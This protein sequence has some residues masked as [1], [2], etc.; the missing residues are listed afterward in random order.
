MSFLLS[1]LLLIAPS[2][3]LPEGVT[4]PQATDFTAV[5]RSGQTFLTWTEEPGITGE[6]YRI[7]RSDLPID[8]VSLPTAD[9]LYEVSEGSAEFYAD[10]YDTGVGGV[11]TSRYLTHFVITDD[12]PE[13]NSS[14][15]LLVWTLDSTDFGGGTS[16]SGYYAIT[17][18]DQGVENTTDFTAA[19]TFGPV[20]ESIQD[21]TPVRTTVDIGPEGT[22]FIQYRDLRNWNPTFHAPNFTNLYYG[23][24]P[25]IPSVARSIQY[26]YVYALYGP[27]P[28]T[29]T[30][31]GPYP[32]MLRLHG[33]QGNA[34]SPLSADPFASY[35][36]YKL[37]P[38][39]VT[40]TW[41]FGFARDHDFRGGGVV[42][43][44]DTIV[45]YTEQRVLDMIV[46]LLAD[47]VFGPDLDPQ[48][49]YSF[50][51]SM[52]GS[53]SLALA[54]RYPDVFAGIY[55]CDPMTNY[56]T[57][58]QAGDTDWTGDA[59]LKWGTIAQNLPVEIDAP[60]GWADHLKVH[61]GTGVWDWQN[62]QSQLSLRV[63][64]EMVPLGTAHGTMDSVIG[65]SNQGQPLPGALDGSRRAWG[66][67]VEAGGHIWKDFQGLPPSMDKDA[68]SVPFDGFG[69][70]RDET[71]PGLSQA[72]SNPP[73][74]PAGAGDFNQIVEWSSS[75]DPF[76]GPPQDDP[77]CWC[78]TLRTVDGSTVT[79][80]V[81]PRRLQ[82]FLVTPGVDYTWENLSL[83]TGTVIESGT[84]IADANGLLT[85]PGVT[86]DGNGNALSLVRSD[87]IPVAEFSASPTTGQAPLTTTF[88]DLSTGQIDTF[89]WDFGDG[90]TSSLANPTHVFASDGSYGVT[91]TVTGSKGISSLTKAGLI[92]V[93]PAASVS[94][95]NGTGVNPSVLSSL[96]L[97]T[98][99][100]T[101]T[102][103]F[104]TSVHPGA[105]LVALIGYEAPLPPLPLVQ[106]ELLVDVSTTI[107]LGLTA[108]VSN[109]AA[110]VSTPIPADLSAL[111]ILVASQG[112]ILGAGSVELTN[113][114]DLI[115]GF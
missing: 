70:I 63:A 103:D 31:G 18:V 71:V 114:L 79:V 51:H 56:Q 111:G 99:S 83:G 61:N 68:N 22:L 15:G 67:Y 42:P 55:A 80:D 91:L 81:T 28:G 23:L 94:T 95:R 88:S 84:I 19:N 59:G 96:D 113:A 5:F 10:R 8:A 65:W 105:T 110:S 53:G 21:P 102:A 47:P 76:A 2:I 3:D 29:C 106:G 107:L 97:P 36:A 98:L 26:A 108:A 90:G 39:D 86:I 11:W 12:G 87:L 93:G 73:L 37:I 72:S 38:I 34:Y 75:W 20:T 33:W 35:C 112:A 6:S 30:M 44:G 85:L 101:W 78:M 14:T 43:G 40:E 25:S 89:D 27:D 7:Y 50:G 92:K 69:V 1:A 57:S 62:H 64:D 82:A 60:N 74:P 45:N 66:T 9:L 54:M 77:D 52:G 58:G 48:R 32:L 46:S 104:D 16:G 4:P 17:T 24:S 13:L 109:D 100:S 49:I 41:W 115:I